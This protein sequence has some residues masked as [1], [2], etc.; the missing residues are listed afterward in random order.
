MNNNLTHIVDGL[1]QHTHKGIYAYIDSNIEFFDYATVQQNVENMIAELRQMGVKPG[2]N[3]AIS[4]T[5]SYAWIVADL[6]IVSLGCCLVAIPEEITLSS[7]LIAQYSLHLVL[8][9]S[10]RH[11]NLVTPGDCVAFL[12]A[13]NPP[14]IRVRNEIPVS[15]GKN[16]AYSVTFSSG[17]SGIPKAMRIS[18]SGTENWIRFL[19][20]QFCL[21]KNDSILIFLPFSHIQQ[22]MLLYV[23]AMVGMDFML[24]SP[25]RLFM[26]L[27]RLKPSVIVAPPMFYESVETRARALLP[28]DHSSDMR[29]TEIQKVLGGRARRLFTGF[30][31]I[32]KETLEFY[33]EAGLPLYE[34]YGVTECGQVCLNT[35]AGYRPGSVGKPVDD[36]DVQLADDGEIMVKKRYPLSLGYVGPVAEHSVLAGDY[37]PTGDIGRFDADGFLYIIGRTKEIIVTRGGYKVHPQVLEED[38]NSCPGVNRAVVFGTDLPSLVALISVDSKITQA[39]KEKIHDY[40][41]ELN[42]NAPSP[43]RI[44]KVVFTDRTFDEESGLLTRSLK[45]NRAAVFNAFKAEIIGNW[46]LS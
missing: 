28:D 12:D 34:G 9:Q 15:E 1:S 23:A 27:P 32:R 4:A 6:A 18:R 45:L 16:D 20:E 41:A 21:T 38:L 24:T 14:G 43:R 29:I 2:M 3:I 39:E 36:A 17:T 26:A 11:E 35:P 13:P 30:A 5:N 22:R 8:V 25:E 40:V 31:P 46:A 33:D 44:G 10:A 42:E 37:Y 19:V 7:E